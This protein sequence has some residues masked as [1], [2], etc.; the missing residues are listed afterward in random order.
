MRVYVALLLITSCLF[1]NTAIAANAES[2]RP[3][4]RISGTPDKQPGL[5]AST[6]NSAPATSGVSQTVR[7]TPTPKPSSNAGNSDSSMMVFLTGIMAVA[8]A[9]LAF[10]NFQLVGVT[11]EM[12]RASKEAADAA[13]QSARAAELALDAE[14]PYVFI[15]NPQMSATDATPLKVFGV[16]VGGEQPPQ[17]TIEVSFDLHDRGKGVAVLR[18][19]RTD[20]FVVP[21]PLSRLVQAEQSR[22]TPFRLGRARWTDFRVRILGAGESNRPYLP[23]FT[24]QKDVWERVLKGDFTFALVG[25][26]SYRDVFRRRFTTTFCFFVNAG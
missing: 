5:A 14:R 23:S 9:F 11:D 25:L 26:L 21:S 1:L 19:I 17:T 12:K 13:R 15:E 10:F 20:L 7:K 4:S 16:V 18:A 22:N 2:T 24:I 6:I 8:T 3:S